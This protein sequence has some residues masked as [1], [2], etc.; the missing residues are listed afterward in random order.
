[1][2]DFVVSAKL[3]KLVAHLMEAVRT[4]GDDR[5]H[6][7][8]V[9]CADRVLGQHLVQILVAHATS[10]IAVTVLLLAEDREVDLAR[11]ENSRKRDGDLLGTIVERPHA[12]D[13][14]QDVGTVAT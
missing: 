14:E 6:L 4:A 5:L 8:A 11:L 10:R 12:T 3:R 2:D 1:M 9:E 7:V 13:P